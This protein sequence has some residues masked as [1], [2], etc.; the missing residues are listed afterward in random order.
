VTSQ[1]ILQKRTEK[2]G[3]TIIAA[4]VPPVF[5]GVKGVKRT[6]SLGFAVKEA[7]FGYLP[8]KFPKSQKTDSRNPVHKVVQ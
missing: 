4:L 3:S 8:W 1:P 6:G 5:G 7:G 2:T